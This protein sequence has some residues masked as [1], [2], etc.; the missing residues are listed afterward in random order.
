MTA[1]NDDYFHLGL[2]DQEVL[3][4]REKYGANLLTPPKRPSLLK[5]YL[6]KFEDPVVRVLL[7]AA[8]FS[9]IISVIE[10]EYA[11]TI[12]IIAAILLATGIGFYFEYDAN[13]KFDL[14]NAVTEET[15][16]K[17]IRNGRIQEIPRKDVVVG[18]IVVLETGEEIP[19]DGELIEAISLQVNESNLTGEPV[20]NKTIIEADFDEEATYA[21]NLVMRGTTVV[22][23]H[24]SMKVLRVGDATEIGKVARQSTEQTTEPTPLNI[25]LTKL[26]NLIGKIGFTVAGLAFLIFFIKD[27]VLYFDFGALNGWHDWLPVLERTLKYFM[28]AVTL[29]VVAVPEGLPM[30]VTLSLALNMRRMLATNN[31]VRK[32]HACETMGAITVICT[33]KTGTLTQNLMQVHEPNFYGLKDGGKLA[34]DDI[35]RLIAEGISANSTAFLEETGEGEKPKGVGNPTEVA[36]LLWLNSQKRNYLELRE[37]AR[38][39]D[40][41]TFST[42]RK[43][44]ATLVKSPLIGKK[45]LYIKGAPEI[46]LGKCKE[47]ILNGRRVDSVEYRSTVEAQLLGYQNMA[48]RTLG[49]AFRLVEDNEPDDC[50]ALVSENNLNF[51][52]VVAISDPIRPDVPAAVAK[53]QSA[54]IGIKIVTG[55]TPGTAT[56][57]ARQIGLWKPEDTERNRITGVAFAELSDEEALDRVMDLKIMS[58]ARPTDKQRLVQLLQQKGAVVAV[59]GDG[60]NDAPALNHAQVGLSMGTGTSVAKEASDITLLDDSFNS[61]GTAVM[62][63]RSLYKNIQ[64]FIVFQLTINFVALLIVLLGSIVGTELPLTVTQ[65]LWV[66]LIMDT[67]AALALASIPPSESVMNDKPRRSTDFIISKAMQHNIF[68]VGTLFLVVLMAMIYY[69]TN[70]DGGMTVQRL[71]IFFTFFVMLQ[72]WNLFNARVFGTTDSAFKGLTKSYGMELIVLAILGGQF[73]IVQ[74]GGAVFRTEPLDWQTWLIII[75]SSSLVLWIGEL[76]RLVKRLTQ[77]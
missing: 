61:I 32:M 68:G 47:V 38:V 46:V 21:S 67:F 52:G 19:A 62:W 4:S 24:G 5:L 16:V 45:V 2:T 77:K 51:L 7:I 55:D 34:D 72:F 66:N 53:C 58:R 39:L 69:F 64:R 75:G 76:I 1:K 30:S 20:I 8:V 65:M 42:E 74:F 63:G 17:V 37:G 36:L 15:L 73:L 13:K 54:G 10:N 27:V 29:I 70:A 31:L 60:T 18:D 48:M 22:D 43:F 57:I 44:M 40:Q 26:A 12:G 6:E 33:D 28:M 9:L 11:E 56:E 50:V 23:G 25:Q 49:F 3:Q 35:S 59:T 71:T 14:L 41:L